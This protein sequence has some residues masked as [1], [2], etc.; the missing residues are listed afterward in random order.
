[1]TALLGGAL[2]LAFAGAAGAALPLAE[3]THEAAVTRGAFL[4]L[5]PGA[6][7]AGMAGAYTALADDASAGSWNPAGLGQLTAPSVLAMH[8]VAVFDAGIS[9]LAF[10]LPAGPG[11]TAVSLAGLFAG[12]V[13][14]R[15]ETGRAIRADGVLEI[16]GSVAYGMAL[17]AG[18]GVPGFGGLTTEVHRD[19]D[20]NIGFGGGVGAIVSA[21]ESVRLGAAVAHLGPASGGFS[22]P[23][24]VRAGA[25]WSASGRVRIVLDATM[26]LVSKVT[27]LAL[28]TEVWLDP[29]LA[30]R[31]G[32]RRALRDQ[33]LGG[34]EGLTAGLG[35]RFGSFGFDYALEGAGEPGW[36]H[37]IS[38]AW[39]PRRTRPVTVV[40]PSFAG[41]DPAALYTDASAKYTAGDYPG[42]ASGVAILLNA[43]RTH[44]RGWQLLGNVRAAQGDQAG[45]L[46]AWR[47]SLRL[48]P[49]NPGLA[50]WVAKQSPQPANAS[51][52]DAAY[53]EAVRLYTAGDYRGAWAK[54]AEALKADP[55]HW[56]SWQILGSCQYALDDLP[57]AAQSFRYALQLHPDNPPLR[58][59]LDRIENK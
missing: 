34:M 8:D 13:D 17:P 56:Q 10:A 21:G 54:S 51:G 23:A 42:A 49:D 57:G 44:W 58:A 32:F 9:Y 6:R 33:G 2:V 16:A 14:G 20:G 38:M 29:R 55:S 18:L 3:T 35:A 12:A 26:P 19:P 52:A 24:T 41:P 43:D 40:A 45:A 46:E 48:N 7:P 50:D 47:E 28:G 11:A 37:R 1:M 59:L 30:L 53:T 25:M 22:L 27:R 15:D 4:Q 31:A 5:G 36:S 39:L